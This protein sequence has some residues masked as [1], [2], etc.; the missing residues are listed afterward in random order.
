MGGVSSL[1]GRGLLVVRSG[2]VS[3]CQRGAGAGSVDA[4]AEADAGP[5]NAAEADDDHEPEA[6]RRER[7]GSADA[8]RA[9][10]GRPS[11]A[12]DEG[13]AAAGRAK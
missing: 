8:R 2:V 4:V 13:G 5:R 10:A 11:V 12:V 9:A 1:V 7:G 3:V 6:E